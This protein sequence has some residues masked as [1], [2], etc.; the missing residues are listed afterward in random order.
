[1]NNV[2]DQVIQLLAAAEALVPTVMT[3]HKERPEH[4]ALCQPVERPYQ[5]SKTTVNH[6]S[7]TLERHHEE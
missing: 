7:Q 5:P 2:P 4:G 1:M 6:K 3:H